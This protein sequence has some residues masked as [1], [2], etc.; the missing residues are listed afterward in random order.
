MEEN[1]EEGK[2]FHVEVAETSV[3]K[4]KFRVIRSPSQGRNQGKNDGEKGIPR[5]KKD[6]EIGSDGTT[7]KEP[8]R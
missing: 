2:E 8:E 3:K 4:G 6:T 7:N 1:Q 5:G